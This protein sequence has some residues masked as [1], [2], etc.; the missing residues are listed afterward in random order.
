MKVTTALATAALL[1]GLSGAALAENKIAPDLVAVD[2]V[3]NGKPVKIQRSDDAKATLPK[4]YQKTSRHCP[5]FCVQP[6]QV[7]PGVATVGELEVLGYL[8]RIADG[9]AN[10]LVVDSRGP[11]WVT[12]GTIPG[13][14][15]VPWRKI[16]TDVSGSFAIEAEAD[17]LGDI[18]IGTFGAKKTDQGYD[19]SGVKTLVL[20]CNGMWCGQSSINIR[21][22][23]KLGYPADKLKWYRGG[24]QDWVTV[25]LTTVSP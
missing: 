23:A 18:L 13:S 3:H 20:F 19:F 12:R 8:K 10:L 9:N 16:N 7:L 4:G 5:P 11:E 22:L 2:V 15:N 1:A 21:T 17:T 6:M 14:V 25:G 24:M